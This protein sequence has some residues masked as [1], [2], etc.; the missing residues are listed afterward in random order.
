[1]ASCFQEQRIC[2]TITHNNHNQYYH[3][4]CLAIEVEVAGGAEVEAGVVDRL[5][6]PS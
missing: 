5:E 2:L 3:N 4:I 6:A 1:M